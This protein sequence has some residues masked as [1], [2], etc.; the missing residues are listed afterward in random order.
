MG[1]E[2]MKCGFKSI[3]ADVDSMIQ[4]LLWLLDIA[5]LAKGGQLQSL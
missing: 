1:L 5:V 3:E 2:F 4:N